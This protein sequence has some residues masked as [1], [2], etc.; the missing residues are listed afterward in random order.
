MPKSAIADLGGAPR[1]MSGQ[2]FKVL[3]VALPPSPRLRR[4]PLASPAEASAEAG[5][6]PLRGHL[7]M[8]DLVTALRPPTLRS[9]TLPAPAGRSSAACWADRRRWQTSWEI[10]AGG[11]S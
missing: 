3:A 1:R 9:R 2:I 4:T 6:G 5:R 11:I 10:H 7:R 8:T